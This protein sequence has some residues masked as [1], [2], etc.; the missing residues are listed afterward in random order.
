MH[1]QSGANKTNRFELFFS[2]HFRKA[3]AN[4]TAKLVNSIS[5][6]S[7][8]RGWFTELEPLAHSGPLIY[9]THRPVSLPFAICTLGFCL[10]LPPVAYYYSHF[11]S[12]YVQCAKK[13][14]HSPSIHS[15]SIGV[16]LKKAL[17]MPIPPLDDSSFIPIHSSAYSSLSFS[18]QPLQTPLPLISTLISPAES[19]SHSFSILSPLRPVLSRQLSPQNISRDFVRNK[20]IRY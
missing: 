2:R 12:C 16:C 8:Y 17:T 14:T 19:P 5:M 11:N 4:T 3:L 1:S 18:T 15:N 10:F 20:R 9:A 6:R 7:L 13:T